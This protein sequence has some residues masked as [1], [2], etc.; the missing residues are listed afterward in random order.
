[1]HQTPSSMST[2][3]RV[4]L[5]DDSVNDVQVIRRFLQRK[6]YEVDIATSGEE[7]LA[8]GKRIPPDIFV[9][10]FRMPGI[11]GFEVTR[12]IKS[13]P[14][15]H[16]IPVLLLTGADAARTVVDGLGAGADDFVTKG[17]DTE[18][19]LARLRAL[20]RVKAYQDQL[21]KLNQQITR[22]LQIARRVQ[23]ALVPSGSFRGPRIEIR[24]AYMPSEALSGDLYD[25]FLRANMTYP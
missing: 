16:T 17:S 1:M 13:D 7:G 3:E 10:D 12:R 6:G 11:D 18:V 4:V 25:Y 19:L 21:R 5:I 8:L 24:S 9:V 15:L 22:D 2:P 20:L 14:Q 23:E